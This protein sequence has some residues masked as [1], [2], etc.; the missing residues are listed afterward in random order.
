MLPK[1]K[2]DLKKILQSKIYSNPPTSL[3]V[4][5]KRLNYEMLKREE[6]DFRERSEG[7]ILRMG[8]NKKPSITQNILVMKKIEKKKRA[9]LRRERRLKNRKLMYKNF[10]EKQD[11]S[12]STDSD[13]SRKTRMERKKNKLKLKAKLK[14]LKTLKAAKEAEL[15]KQKKQEKKKKKLEQK[16]II[17]KNQFDIFRSNSPRIK[18]GDG[19]IIGSDGDSSEAMEDK[20]NRTISSEYRGTFNITKSLSRS[21]RE[22]VQDSKFLKQTPKPTF[23]HP[24]LSLI[25][26]KVKNVYIFKG[27]ETHRKKKSDYEEFKCSKNHGQSVQLNRNTIKKDLQ[28]PKDTLRSA[29]DQN[30]KNS[31][32]QFATNGDMM[33]GDLSNLSRI[34]DPK[35]MLNTLKRFHSNSSAAGTN[36]SRLCSRKHTASPQFPE[37]YNI[38]GERIR[39]QD[40]HSHK[41]TE[42][43][44]RCII[45]I[46]KTSH[47]RPLFN[48][49][50]SPA[51][52]NIRDS[53][54]IRNI[55][56]HPKRYKDEI[57]KKVEE[58]RA[59]QRSTSLLDKTQ[60]YLS[61]LASGQN[62]E[63]Y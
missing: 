10:E 51:F 32:S 45:D 54:T 36:Y 46:G 55:V 28:I 43:K 18:L 56:M 19:I 21:K 37:Y 42:D 44:F 23:Y 33:E 4:A 27:G 17:D 24:K 58:R 39:L 41:Y 60:L 3:N 2:E 12:E 35:P 15:R 6:F 40:T 14:R 13:V 52:Y 8:V 29:R 9:E 49:I 30:N 7:R 16:P 34:E 20:A 59:S 62:L 11:S 5:L 1:T 61:L 50:T 63:G 25:Q 38:Q 57:K 47:R 22:S 26:K 48:P 31:H 53:Q